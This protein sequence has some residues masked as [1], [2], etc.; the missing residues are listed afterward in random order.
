MSSFTKGR[1]HTEQLPDPDQDHFKY[2]LDKANTDCLIKAI[3]KAATAWNLPLAK[4][5]IIFVNFERIDS[6]FRSSD[7]LRTR[8]ELILYKEVHK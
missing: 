1:F 8:F 3:N 6:S 2:Y 7:R 4:T 5:I